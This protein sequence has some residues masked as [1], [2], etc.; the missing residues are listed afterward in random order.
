MNVFQLLLVFG[1][2]A[3]SL[4]VLLRFLSGRFG[5]RAQ[6]GLR[7]LEHLVTIGRIPRSW[8]PAS[9]QSL[10]SEHTSMSRDAGIPHEAEHQARRAVRDRLGKYKSLAQKSPVFADDNGR[11]EVI[12]AIE[13]LE[14]KVD[15]GELSEILGPDPRLRRHVILFDCGDTLVD[16]GSEVHDERGV[17]VRASLI[18]GARQTVA[19]LIRNGFTVALVADGK[20]ESFERI[21][22]SHRMWSWF[23]STAI[24]EDLGVSKPDGRMFRHALDELEIP[25]EEYDSV[26]MVGNNLPVDIKGAN[27]L[28]LISVWLDW[29]PR[30]TK[31]PA[32]DEEQP[33]FTIKKP[34]ELLRVIER[35]ESG[36]A[37]E[38]Q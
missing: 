20:R 19:Q 31:V 25:P 36:E 1:L 35:L 23:Q 12:G 16:E 3:F 29:A 33:D 13:R 24:S 4:V 37:Y 6:Y 21:L 5:R 17:V 30:R 22:R 27:R 11:Q 38:V 7:V 34:L 26:V 2:F 15:S 14:G 28:G 32:D 8:V 18:P 10:A 9:S